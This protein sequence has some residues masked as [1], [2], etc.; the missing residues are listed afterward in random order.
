MPMTLYSQRY[1][2]KRFIASAPEQNLQSLT[3]ERTM[4]KNNQ[5]FRE[6][7][8]PL[9]A[10]NY[11]V[12]PKDLKT[13]N[14]L[15]TEMIR[16]VHEHPNEVDLDLYPLSKNLSPYRF[17]KIAKTNPDFAEALEVAQYLISSRIKAGW[18]SREM[19]TIYAKEML[20]E[21][22]KAYREWVNMKVTM[23]IQA[24]QAEAQSNS[25]EPS[26]YTIIMPSIPTTSEVPER[27]IDETRDTDTL[28]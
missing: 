14:K 11:S 12:L 13:Q 27:I 10:A 20:P 23:A 26:N 25:K 7:L 16:W 9:P 24:R 1:T 28:K 6:K 8:I 17:Y 18:R 3:S 2:P 21:Y 22:N 15:A 19:D 4:K 5:K